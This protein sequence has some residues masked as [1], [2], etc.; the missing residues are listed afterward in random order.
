MYD[1][2]VGVAQDKKKALDLYVQSA[3]AGHWEARVGAA[4][5]IIEGI[6]APRDDAIAIQWLQPVAERQPDQ[7]DTNQRLLIGNAQFIL[8]QI[9]HEG[10]DNVPRNADQ[11]FSWFEKAARNGQLNSQRLYGQMLRDRGQYT[12]AVTWLREAATR[13]DRAAQNDLG[14]M[15]LQ[16]QGVGRSEEEGIA[17]LL[18][19][20]QQGSPTARNTL[21]TLGVD[22]P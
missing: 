2:G 11:A 14:N 20:Y 17:W 5:L 9:Y 21:R 16:G 13:G 15:Y 12:E 10:V 1:R 3:N 7:L 8:G 18:R 6:A 4:F 19:A 22:A